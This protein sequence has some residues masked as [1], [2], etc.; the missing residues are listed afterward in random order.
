MHMI[1]RVSSI[2]LRTLRS[3]NT[4]SIRSLIV[5]PILSIKPTYI[6]QTQA[7]INL[8]PQALLLNLYHHHHHYYSTKT[9]PPPPPPQDKN[10][11]EKN[12]NRISRAFTFSLST[13]LLVV[14]Q[15][16]FPY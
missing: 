10:A 13:L 7:P 1:Q 9:V 14:E 4:G 12:F 15:Q 6:R 11:K 3:S 16:E 2:G 5:L 8:K